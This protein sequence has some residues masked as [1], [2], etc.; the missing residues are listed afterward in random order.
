MK[1]PMVIDEMEVSRVRG[2]ETLSA[3]ITQAD[4]QCRLWFRWNGELSPLPG[5]TLLLAALQPAMAMG[6][7]LVME[8]PT[9]ARLIE[10]IST[11]QQQLQMLLPHLT[12]IE[13]EAENS[14]QSTTGLNS[15]ASLP[16]GILFDGG[17][18]AFYTFHQHQQEIQ[19]VIYVSDFDDDE[20]IRYRQ[21]NSIKS[22][23]HRAAELGKTL[24]QVDTNLRQF[25]RSFDYHPRFHQSLISGV[26]GILLSGQ[27]S[28]LFVP[29]P[30]LSAGLD[31]IFNGTYP[32]QQIR[33]AHDGIDVD[34]LIKMDALRTDQTILR[35][36]QVCWDNPQ[37][38]YNCGRCKKCTRRVP[39]RRLVE[40]LGRES[41]LRQRLISQ[42]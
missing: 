25:L 1:D 10:F 7:D 26:I 35:S 15:Q 11:T 6:C 19:T 33:F 29:N 39:S 40:L 38:D 27:L 8:E 12:I 22:A 14:H 18:D 17:I 5:D 24:L 16:T 28:K 37:R 32:D 30:A 2:R 21:G 9:S 4:R 13:I 36:L 3:S 20:E 23:G 42:F 34:P 41:R 31:R